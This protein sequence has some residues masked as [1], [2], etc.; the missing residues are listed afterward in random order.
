MN[1]RKKVEATQ[2]QTKR[3]LR[4]LIAKE[5]RASKKQ[6]RVSVGLDL[7]DLYR[8][9]VTFLAEVLALVQQADPTTLGKQLK[10]HHRECQLTYRLCRNPVLRP[11][12]RIQ[13][14]AVRGILAAHPLR[15]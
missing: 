3:S 6:W 9:K 10:A 4:N 13:L 5:I 14:R 8:A 7:R 1:P 2:H 12:F 11:I 15:F